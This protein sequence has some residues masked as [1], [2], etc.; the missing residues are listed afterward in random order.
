MAS[1]TVSTIAKRAF[2]GVAG[3]IGGVV[4]DATYT[5]PQ[6]RAGFN[7]LT[8]N[9]ERTPGTEHPCRVVVEGTNRDNALVGSYTIGEK[10]RVVLIEGLEVAPTENGRLFWR[11]EEQILTFVE[12]ILFSGTLFR[13]VVR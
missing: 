7:R 12:D 5:T 13:A 3:S 4:F 2:D 9:S 6:G 11:G 8:G 10:E 1:R